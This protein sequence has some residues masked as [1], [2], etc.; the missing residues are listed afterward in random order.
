MLPS[1]GPLTIDSLEMKCTAA[2]FL[3]SDVGDSFGEVPAMA[4]KVGS[5]VWALAV[6]GRPAARSGGWLRSA[7]RVRSGPRHSQ[8]GPVPAHQPGRLSG[9]DSSLTRST[10]SIGPGLRGPKPP[11]C[12]LLPRARNLAS[13]RRSDSLRESPVTIL[14][15]PYVK[16]PSWR[17][18]F[19]HQPFQD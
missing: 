3:R 11:S 14:V 5:V 17:R 10:R 16:W 12:P 19:V 8:S 7:A 18:K 6:G 1:D 15:T 2:P 13:S 4:T 9:D